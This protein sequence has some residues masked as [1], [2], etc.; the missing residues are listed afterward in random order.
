MQL[1]RPEHIRTN[2]FPQCCQNAKQHSNQMK[3]VF[4]NSI[5]DGGSGRLNNVIMKWEGFATAYGL[6]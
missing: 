6:F 5:T 3:S 1:R 2:F 4:L